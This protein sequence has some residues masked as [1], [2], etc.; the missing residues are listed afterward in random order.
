M[1]NSTDILLEY[2]RAELGYRG[3]LDARTDLIERQV[4]D[5]FTVVEFAMF[6]QT[7]FAIELEP[8]DFVQTNFS[9]LA[10]L[11]ALIESKK[12]ALSGPEQARP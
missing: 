5:S 2:I 10:S 7:H 12:Q 9:S 11:S 3:E 8:D 1:A 6:I 4:L